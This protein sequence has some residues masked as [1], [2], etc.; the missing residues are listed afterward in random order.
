MRRTY[1]FNSSGPIVGKCNRSTAID[2]WA[3]MTARE[4]GAG[5][6][7][8]EVLCRGQCE[9][10]QS[11]RHRLSVV[12]NYKG[13]QVPSGLLLSFGCHLALM[14]RLDK[15]TCWHLSLSNR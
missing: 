13:S 11:S 7:A 9:S 10:S 15:L 12:N 1:K 5:Q 8:V 4:D 14:S 2:T 6:V 3:R